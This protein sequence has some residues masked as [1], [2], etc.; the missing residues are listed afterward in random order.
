M[1]TVTKELDSRTH[2]HWLMISLV[3][4]SRMYNLR[5]L[6]VLVSPEA[7]AAARRYAPTEDETQ[8]FSQVLEG[9][10]QAYS[11]DEPPPGPWVRGRLEYREMTIEEMREL[12]G[13]YGLIFRFDLIRIDK[14]VAGELDYDAVDDV[15]M[16]STRHRF[17]TWRDI[18]GQQE[19]AP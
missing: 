16:Y 8:T 2:L 14:N 11:G 6:Y 10:L 3:F 17:M 15:N 9:F 13:L 19:G 7:I 4:L 5:V 18:G 1:G 12:I